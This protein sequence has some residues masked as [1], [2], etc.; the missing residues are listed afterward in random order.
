MQKIKKINYQALTIKRNKFNNI[1]LSFDNKII[2]SLKIN[3]IVIKVHYTSLN[4]KDILLTK[5]NKGLIRKFPHVPGI[6]ASGVVV[7]SKNN[8][9]KKGDKVFVIARP[10]GISC[11]GGLS[12]YIK[13]PYSWVN[14]ITNGISLKEIMVFGTAGYTA[15]IAVNHI[16]KYKI[17]KN[18]SPIVVTGSSGGVGSIC[19]YLLS[20]LG[21]NILALTSNIDNKNYL[22]QIGATKVDLISNFI[23]SSDMPLLK[24][25][26]SAVIDNLG[27]PVINFGIKQINPNGC[28]LSIGN[29]LDQ[30]F[31]TS[32]LP[33]ILR[34]IVLVGIN[35]ESITNIQ[36]R[37]IFRD[38]CINIKNKD[39]KK[40][41][42]VTNFKDI[43]KNL[44]EMS[45]NKHNGRTIVKINH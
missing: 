25:K 22:K 24:S 45:K 44:K 33:F 32:I 19:I 11:D 40:L 1:S 37:K 31:K 36:R 15:Q 5:G 41:Y 3:E 8:K 23:N 42:K 13:V 4:Y 6:D 12:E 9:F 35:A 18:N 29:V 39:L 16:I 27:G 7:F 30:N 17:K 2:D 28:F 38:I 14:K 34:S 43:N 10:L 26:Y 20:K 21:Y